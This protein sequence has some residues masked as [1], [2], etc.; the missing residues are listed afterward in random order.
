MAFTSATFGRQAQ[1]WLRI[2]AVFELGLAAV[3]VVAGTMASGA[4]AGLYLTS[5]ILA[6]V[7]LG[8]LTGAAV[9]GSG[10]A[11]VERIDA[12]GTPGSATITGV[13][14]TGGYMNGSPR[15]ALDLSVQLP[16]RPAYPA[17]VTQFVPLIL[18]SRVTPGQTLAVK[19][20]QQ[21]PSKLV[22]DWEF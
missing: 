9:I 13:T 6:V 15:L 4:R 16:G 2:V 19:A 3:F 17:T 1:R 20:D 22:L 8:L 11:R 5:G 12:T 21:D 14:Q 10:V 7:G 18:L